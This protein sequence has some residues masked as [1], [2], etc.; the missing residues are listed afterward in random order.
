MELHMLE[1]D[2]RV[3]R[4]PR[5]RDSLVFWWSPEIERLRRQGRLTEALGLAW[6]RMEAVEDERPLPW[7]WAWGVAVLARQM[8]WYELEIEV[9]ERVL[10]IAAQGGTPA[11]PWA[12]RLADARVLASTSAG[13]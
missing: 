10:A 3:E 6:S 9:I 1:S 11:A 5:A 4:V 8:R 13:S 12:S 2:A 7:G